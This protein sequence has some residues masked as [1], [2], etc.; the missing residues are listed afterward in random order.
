MT[1]AHQPVPEAQQPVEQAHAPV[2]PAPESASRP[3]LPWERPAPEPQHAQAEAPQAEPEPEV[4]ATPPSTEPSTPAYDPEEV[5]RLK[6]QAAQFEELQR[7]VA[8]E[9]ARLAREQEAQRRE[10]EFKQRAKE[11]WDISQ[12]YDTREEQEDYYLRQ[13]AA[14]RAEQEQ[15]LQQQIESERQKLLDE[16]M[17][18]AIAGFPD[19]LK[20]EY[21][22]D[23]AEV[24]DLRTLTDPQQMTAVAQGYKRMREK[25][26]HLEQIAAQA[27]ANTQAQKAQAAVNPGNLSGAP[28][29]SE[30]IGPVRAGTRESRELLARA[31]GLS[32]N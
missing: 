24:E 9:Q 30:E 25:Y 14:L 27:Y 18:Q 1:D 13:M 11:I 31:L 8:E 32:P 6:Q 4:A 21:G 17:A 23:D 5:E 15:S 16:R 20:N 26:G 19:Y 12:R 3:P 2:A 29:S 10:E 22:L 7:A 28:A